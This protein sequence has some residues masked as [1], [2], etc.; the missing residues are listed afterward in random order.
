V[1]VNTFLTTFDAL[2]GGLRVAL[3]AG[4]V[5]VAA[6][7][8][9]SYAVRTRRINPF[10]PVARLTRGSIDPLFAPVERRVLRAGGRPATAPWWALGAVVVVGII[11]ISALGFVRQQVGMAGA[12]V[13]M[14]G[15]G[16]AMLLIAWTFGILQIALF[17]RVISSWIRVSPHSP[18]LRWS[19]V[20]TDWIINP[21][22]QVIPQIGMIDISPIAAY[23]LLSIVERLVMGLL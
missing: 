1:G 22:R 16:L 20:L 23:F 21:L 13:Q 19:F 5:V 15:R 3:L 2:I 10:S 4:G 6:L 18:W 17:V 12:A 9:L 7:A 14:G 8:G 11:L